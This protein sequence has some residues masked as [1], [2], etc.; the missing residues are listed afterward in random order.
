MD[1]VI[2]LI[3]RSNQRGGRMLS[4][5]DL[6]EAGTLTRY[7]LC[8]LVARIESG[9]SWLVGAV[10]GGA[11]KTT[12]MSALL[13]M[14][15]REE[16]VRLATPSTGWERSQPGECIVAYEIGRG[17]YEAYVWGHDL[18]RMAELGRSGCRIVTNLHTDT[19]EQAHEQIVVQNGVA[20][21]DFGAF[22]LFLPVT[23]RRGVR[24]ARRTI[25][26][27]HY[28]RAGEWRELREDSP[29]AREVEIGGFV[30]LCLQRGV[31]NVSEVREAWL[32]WADT[33][34]P[35]EN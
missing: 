4:V 14:L 11:G 28:V 20:E 24:G 8:W 12:V 19:L 1:P 30:D 22:G 5:I 29:S 9:S 6:L 3:E 27:I 26:S 31:R 2:S 17:P 32:E 23:V 33:R 21:K 25:E 13:G 7:Q 35:S 18:R 16:R 34:S 15:P 10:P